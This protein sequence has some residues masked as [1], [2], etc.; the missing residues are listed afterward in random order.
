MTVRG[1]T[2]RI[3]SIKFSCVSP[4]EIRKMSATKIITADTYDDEG[5]PI[6]MGL[7]D[8]H[9]GVIEP[10]LRC[11]TCGCKVDECPG[12]FGHIDLAMPVIHVGFIKD[13]KMLLESTCCQC[14]RLML[15]ADQIQARRESME[16]ME[17][18]GGGTID[19][20]IFSKETAKDASGK[21]VC[22]YCGAE[23]IKIKLDKPTTFREVEDNHKLTPKEVRERLERIPDDDLVTLGIDPSTCRPEWMVLTALAVPPVTVRPSITLDSGD[24]SEDD[25]THKLVDVLR[26]NQRLRENRDAGA[27]QLIVE[28]LWELLQYHVTTYFD[29]QTSGI[30]PAR[31]RSGRP[32]KT[33]AQRLKGKEGRFRSNLSGKRVNFSARTVISPDPNLSINEVGVPT[34]AARELTVPVHVNEHNIEIPF[35]QRDIHIKNG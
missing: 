12:H 21:G 16:R 19:V 32:L 4:D 7:M 14:G 5:Y 22:P 6:D 11:K 15:S 8:P 1:I 28:D 35:P 26:I 34:I 29:N 25:L 10:G 20:K 30:P 27:P 9:M 17:E 3:G 33:L 2:K 13:I 31:H 24:R 23:Q 18:L